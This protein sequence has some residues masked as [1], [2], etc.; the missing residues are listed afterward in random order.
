MAFIMVIFIRCHNNYD[1]DADAD[2]DDDDT[3]TMK[4]TMMMMMIMMTMM[5]FTTVTLD[6][7]FFSSKIR[8]SLARS[9]FSVSSNS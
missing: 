1:D 9:S 4:M 5:S 3:T 7:S 6:R 2:D 8:L